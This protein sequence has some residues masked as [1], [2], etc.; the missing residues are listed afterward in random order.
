M[1]VCE[2]PKRW[3]AQTVL[4]THTLCTCFY[5]VN[6]IWNTLMEACRECHSRSNLRLVFIHILILYSYLLSSFAAIT[7]ALK[8]ILG[9]KVWTLSSLLSFSFLYGTL[10][11]KSHIAVNYKNQITVIIKK[12][13]LTQRKS[14]IARHSPGM[15]STK[16]VTSVYQ[17]NL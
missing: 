13:K 10:L 12:V 2:M 1:P 7:P 15:Y 4:H 11:N 8:R 3:E 14:L 5:P 6:E 17:K 9:M 16:D